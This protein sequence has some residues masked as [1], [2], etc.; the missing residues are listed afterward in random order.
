MRSSWRAMRSFS[1]FVIDA[2]GLCSP[3]RIVVSKM[4]NLSLAMVPPLRLRLPGWLAAGNRA[5]YELPPALLRGGPTTDCGERMYAPR[6]AA[7]GRPAAGRRR[8]EAA[9]R[10]GEA[11][12]GIYRLFRTRSSFGGRQAPGAGGGALVRRFT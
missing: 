9:M 3:S 10:R 7:A 5:F 11:C 6:G 8:G 12:L 4:I 2:P 1:S